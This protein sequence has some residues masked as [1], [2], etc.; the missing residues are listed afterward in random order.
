MGCAFFLQSNYTYQCCSQKFIYV[1]EKLVRALQLYLEIKKLAGQSADSTSYIDGVVR[2]LQVV[3]A[4]AVESISKV[5]N[6][7][8]E[9]M[10]SV[11]NTERK[12][13]EIM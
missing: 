7:S 3:V 5:N 1:T 9:Q 6:L 4:N 12:Y 10:E 8:K 11:L 13:E 2:D